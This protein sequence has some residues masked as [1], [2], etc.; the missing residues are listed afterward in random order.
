MFVCSAR[1][2]S[3][4]DSHSSASLSTPLP[5]LSD[6]LIER[7]LSGADISLAGQRY[8]SP[9]NT[10][11]R[12]INACLT[13]N[14]S[15]LIQYRCLFSSLPSICN[16]F[17]F[18]SRQWRLNWLC[19]GRA[20]LIGRRNGLIARDYDSPRRFL[21]AQPPARPWVAQDSAPLTRT[22][23]LPAGVRVTQ[24]ATRRSSLACLLERPFL[25]LAQALP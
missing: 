24:L 4:G 20:Y 8:L 6:Y 19:A 3:R 1:R 15:T 18:V 10:D 5:L 17:V 25:R 12:A 13:R 11:S 23:T 14:V 21:S 7:Y 2:L 16:R 9:I 22:C